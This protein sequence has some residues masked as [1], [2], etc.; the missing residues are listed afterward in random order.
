[1]NAVSIPDLASFRDWISARA[2]GAGA[3]TN[4]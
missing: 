3:A 2:D 4:A 1:M